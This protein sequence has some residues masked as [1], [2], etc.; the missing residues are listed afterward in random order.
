METKAT[1]VVISELGVCILRPLSLQDVPGSITVAW[2]RAVGGD[3]RCH[4][5]L[6]MWVI[7]WHCR[8]RESMKDSFVGAGILQAA[9]EEAH[10]L[11]DMGQAAG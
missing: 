2:R 5:A 4:A 6:V 9:P 11:A 3:G 10:T 1:M 8:C 7:L